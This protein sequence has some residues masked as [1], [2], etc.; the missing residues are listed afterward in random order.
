MDNFLIVIFIIV[1]VG[2]GMTT[3]YLVGSSHKESILMEQM[4][5]TLQCPFEII[6]TKAVRLRKL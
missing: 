2:I 1:C 6:D 5:R 4:N 3:G